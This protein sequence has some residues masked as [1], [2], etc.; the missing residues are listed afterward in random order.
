MIHA[1]REIYLN[2]EV[3]VFGSMMDYVVNQCCL[4]G[5]E[6]LQMFI[7]S[8]LAEQF[9][10]GNPRIIAGKSGIELTYE[11]IRFSTGKEV[12]AS[13]IIVEYHSP[14]YWAGWAL[15]H[16]QW[17]TAKS[18]ASI[19]RVMKFHDMV[20]MYPTFHEVDI[21]KFFATALEIHNQKSPQTNL[22][23]IRE[24]V[25]FSQI[26][27]AEEANVS[28][29]SIQEYEQRSEDINKTQVIV[30]A[31]IARTLGCQIDDLMEIE[32]ELHLKS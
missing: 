26:Q 13:T 9:A 28:L 1:Y 30:V 6:Y 12:D 11:A 3:D 5:D 18:F 31:K 32:T 2:N 10:S 22:E 14:E 4:S 19:L 25:G 21:T 20:Q 23:R 24:L 8:G 16:Y 27:L 7:V 29:Q 17:Y 15:A